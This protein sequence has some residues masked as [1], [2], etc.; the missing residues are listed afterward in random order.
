[1]WSVL[2]WSDQQQKQRRTKR[3]Q[4]AA[5]FANPYIGTIEELQSRLYGILEEDEL[6]FYK[7]E[8]PE[9]YEF[10]SPAAIE[11]LYRL[12][13]YFGWQHH[14]YRYGPYTKDSTVIKLAR[15]I[16][17]VFEDRKNFSGNAF[18]FTVDERA[19]LGEV[20]VRYTGRVT[21]TLPVF[22]SLAL[23]QFEE[24]ISNEQSRHAVLFQSKAVRDIL[25]AI[26]KAD[27]AEDL[28]G[29]ERLIVLQNLLVDL[30]SYLENTE[31]FQ[32]SVGQLRK[33]GIRKQCIPVS[34]PISRKKS[35]TARI[36]H[37]AQGRIRLGIGR[38]KADGD[39][40]NRLQCLLKSVDD[41]RSIR[42]NP[43]AASLTVLYSPEIPGV[44][45]AGRIMKIVEEAV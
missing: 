24:E 13:Q 42:I 38:L 14:I 22:E 30:Q 25:S 39:Y 19:S 10:G 18:R 27:K 41:I 37:Q 29:R 16:G 36:L 33:A 23:F 4:E 40:A 2:T 31:G 11:I 28:E 5:M 3:D 20:V 26:D 17:E 21:A 45:F 12:S 9:K 6:A 34:Q 15:Q 7:K 43:A 44:E 8:Y 35:G 32:V 1:V